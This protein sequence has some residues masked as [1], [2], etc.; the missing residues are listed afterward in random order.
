MDEMISKLPEK[1]FVTGTDTGVGKTF[2]CAALM[3]V[4]NS[5]CYWKPVQTGS[6]EG[7]DTDW[8]RSV[9]GLPKERFLPEA[10]CFRKPL[11]PHAA[12][13]LEGVAIDMCSIVL[14][15]VEGRLIVEGAGGVM[16]PL[17]DHH[18]MIDLMK[19]LGLPVLVVARSTL[20]T[21]NHTLLTLLALRNAGLEVCG[22]I[23]NGPRNESNRRAIE[24]FGKTVVLAEITPLDV[25]NA[26]TLRKSL[27]DGWLK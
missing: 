15:Q 13:A 10:Y 14:P 24:Q 25:V 21:I 17:N 1:I 11:S 4:L 16:V 26:G 19:H 7:T 23:M 2:V 5:S 18:L 9:T 20:G 22:V 12:S 27:L 6:E 3:T 8:I